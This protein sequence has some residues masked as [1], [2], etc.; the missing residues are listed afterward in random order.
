MRP[1]QAI[2]D[3]VA[4]TATID[5]NHTGVCAARCRLKF[6]GVFSRMVGKYAAGNLPI[7]QNGAHDVIG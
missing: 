3:A 6:M 5:A 4:D 2:V 7:A 1:A